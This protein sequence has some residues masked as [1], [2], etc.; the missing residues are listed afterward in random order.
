MQRQPEKPTKIILLF[1]KDAHMV[2]KQLSK[3]PS[4]LEHPHVEK[5]SHTD[6]H[7][8]FRF[9]DV[10]SK[11]SKYLIASI[12]PDVIKHHQAEGYEQKLKKIV[13]DAHTVVLCPISLKSRSNAFQQ[14]LSDFEAFKEKYG[15][16]NQKPHIQ[17]LNSSFHELLEPNK[18]KL[19]GFL[20]HCK[21]LT[22]EIV[23]WLQDLPKHVLHS[24]ASHFGRQAQGHDRKAEAQKQAVQVHQKSM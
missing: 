7:S 16:P 6:E 22:E 2:Y 10:E 3:E 11:D 4:A 19:E 14:T 21:T 1:G 13:A 18:S 5:D 23:S 17:Y 20:E 24:L 8:T 15:S 9:L 12:P